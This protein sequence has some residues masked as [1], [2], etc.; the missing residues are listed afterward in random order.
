MTDDP[1]QPDLEAIALRERLDDWDVLVRLIRPEDQ[2]P[3]SVDEMVRDLMHPL[4]ERQ[5]IL[6]AITR[7]RKAGLIHRTYDDLLFPT[8]AALRMHE[9]DI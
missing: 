8:R 4:T 5:T 3:W 7:L 9:I 6:N 2:R 1:E